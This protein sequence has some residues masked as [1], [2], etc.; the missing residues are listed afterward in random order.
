ME[1]TAL[2]NTIEAAFEEREQIG[3]GT[4]P[5]V[6]AA[7]DAALDGLDCGRFRVAEKIG[8]SWH[9]HQW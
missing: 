3:P 9:V 7:V 6:R 2:R 5:E 4:G 8:G 1:A